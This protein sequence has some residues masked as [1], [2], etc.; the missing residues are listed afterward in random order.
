MRPP[1]ERARRPLDASALTSVLC[2]VTLLPW[3][4]PGRRPSPLRSLRRRIGCCPE[5]PASAVSRVPATNYRNHRTMI[6]R[7]VKAGQYDINPRVR[8]RVVLQ[9]AVGVPTEVFNEIRDWIGSLGLTEIMAYVGRPAFRVPSDDNF[10]GWGIC[11]LEATSGDEQSILS[12]GRMT[13]IKL[14]APPFLDKDE[15]FA[16]HEWTTELM[17]SNPYTSEDLTCQ[18]PKAP[19]AEDLVRSLIVGGRLGD[20]RLGHNGIVVGAESHRDT[21]YPNPVK[22]SDVFRMLLEKATGLKVV[23]SQAGRYAEQIIKKMGSLQFNC[24]VFKFRGVR[25]VIAKLSTARHSPRATCTPSCHRR[26]PTDLAKTGGRI[27]TTKCP[28]DQASWI[29]RGFLTNCLRKGSSVLGCPLSAPA[30]ERP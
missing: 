24:R 29:S 7:V 21:V 3:H 20:V 27:F 9:K 12:D 18:L 16:E 13:P 2:W 11:D 26:R 22:T 30:G 28:A 25:E 10:I 6:E 17:I 4:P 23:P 8:N 1:E 14:M 5:V 15:R 19:G